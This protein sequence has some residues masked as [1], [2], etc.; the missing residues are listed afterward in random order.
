MLGFS[1]KALDVREKMK[2]QNYMNLKF[3][4]KVTKQNIKQ[5]IVTD[6]PYT[7]IGSLTLTQVLSS[8]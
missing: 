8:R 1:T 2:T 6:F 5:Y 3:H 7:V 4:Q